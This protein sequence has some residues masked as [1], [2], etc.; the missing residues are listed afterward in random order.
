MGRGAPATRGPQL[1]G[2]ITWA[3]FGAANQTRDSPFIAARID[4][5]IDSEASG[6]DGMFFVT[7]RTPLV[8]LCLCRPHI[9]LSW[10]VPLM[11]RRKMMSDL[12][13]AR[14]RRGKVS[15]KV[16]DFQPST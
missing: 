16:V 2:T 14:A 8:C 10:P 1:S 4:R 13:E 9:R 5:N 12:F 15:N 7:P 6:R 11:E 3:A